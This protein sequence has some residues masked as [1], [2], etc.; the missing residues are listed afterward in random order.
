MLELMTHC[1]Y[2][3]AVDDAR[4]GF[5]EVGLP[6]V[7]G[8]EGC[9]W[10][11]RKADSADWPKL[12]E[13][14][15]T[16]RPVRASKAVGWLVDYAGPIDEA[17]KKAWQVVTHGEHGLKRRIVEKGGLSGVPTDLPGLPASDGPDNQAARKAIMDSVQASCGASLGEALEVQARHSGGFMQSKACQRGVIGSDYKKT[18]KV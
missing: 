5:P 7:P 18:M 10:P 4:L 17:L 15:L 6:V 1:H 11:F 9:H 16:G 13:L 2:L 12:L 3:I 8:M 14:L